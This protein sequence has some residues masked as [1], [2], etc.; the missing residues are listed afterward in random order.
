MVRSWSG[1]GPPPTPCWEKF[2][3]NPLIFLWGFFS[4]LYSITPKKK[5]LSI[6]HVK[7]FRL[8]LSGSQVKIKNLMLSWGPGW[9]RWRNC[10]FSLQFY[11]LEITG[12]WGTSRCGLPVLSP[13]CQGVQVDS[14]AVSLFTIHEWGDG[15]AVQ[16]QVISLVQENFSY[17]DILSITTI[18]WRAFLPEHMWHLSC[19]SNPRDHQDNN[20]H[21]FQQII[22]FSIW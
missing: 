8:A 9:I 10:R 22:S 14:I 13:A 12:R 2:P 17:W 3:N 15:N 6:L 20:G 19:T 1:R 5:H 11:H 18:F 16:V 21:V 7:L 4:H